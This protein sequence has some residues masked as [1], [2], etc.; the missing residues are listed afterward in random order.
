MTSTLTSTRS[1][2]ISYIITDAFD[3]DVEIILTGQTTKL[4]SL[5]DYIMEYGQEEGKKRHLEEQISVEIEYTQIST[6]RTI[7]SYFANLTYILQEPFASAQ[8][9]SN[10]VSFLQL[11]S[12]N[13]AD[14][15]S[16]SPVVLPS[17]YQDVT[18]PE[19]DETESGIRWYW[20]L[21]LIGG[22]VL[23]LLVQAAFI[24]RK[25]MAREPSESMKEDSE[26]RKRKSSERSGLDGATTGPPLCESSSTYA[27]H[28]ITRSHLSTCSEFVFTIIIPAGKIGCIIDTSPQRGPYICQIHEFSPLRDDIQVGDRLLAVDDDDVRGM[29][30]IGVSKLLGSRSQNKE[31]KLTVMREVYYDQQSGDEE[32]NQCMRSSISSQDPPGSYEHESSHEFHEMWLAPG[33]RRQDESS[34]NTFENRLKEGANKLKNAS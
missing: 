26:R 3:V 21:V 2:P 20:I 28:S 19:D 24:Y 30:A 14:V 18:S 9:R 34:T 25:R 23:V 33:W 11:L 32:A 27:T 16:V 22:I 29:S 8:S 17:S 13:Y 10:Y 7:D 5:G 15:S 12:P 6:Y 1:Y 31:R 4:N